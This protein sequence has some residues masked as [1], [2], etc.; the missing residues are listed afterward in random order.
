[1]AKW[2]LTPELLVRSAPCAPPANFAYMF[3][4]PYAAK[5]VWGIFPLLTLLGIVGDA[6]A[7]ELYMYTWQLDKSNPKQPLHPSSSEL[8]LPPDLP[9]RQKLLW[10]Q[11]DGQLLQPDV[12][13]A[14]RFLPV[15]SLARKGS[16]KAPSFHMLVQVV[17]ANE[18]FRELIDTAGTRPNVE[19]LALFRNLGERT[20]QRFKAELDQLELP[21]LSARTVIEAREQVRLLLELHKRSQYL[22]LSA[23]EQ[24]SMLMATCH[25]ANLSARVAF[26]TLHEPDENLPMYN[27]CWVE[28]FVPSEGWIVAAIPRALPGL[29]GR[30]SWISTE[31]SASEAPSKPIELHSITSAVVYG[32]V[33]DG[34]SASSSQAIYLAAL[35]EAWMNSKT[36]VFASNVGEQ[37]FDDVRANYRVNDSLFLAE[38]RALTDVIPTDFSLQLF[39]LT[40][41]SRQGRSEEALPM[42]QYWL[43]QHHRLEPFDRSHL[44]WS[45]A[46]YLAWQGDFDRADY[47]HKQ[48]SKLDGYLPNRAKDADWMRIYQAHPE[49]LGASKDGR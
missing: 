13:G 24:A 21:Q 17:A 22:Q 5:L 7:Q 25:K 31:L 20:A 43:K 18:R 47:Y 9:G 2:A 41:L 4:Y 29:K 28:V 38:S 39:R 6:N 1:M 40:A 32:F 26:G 45:F 27:T 34:A 23:V 30:L 19:D 49:A 46:K 15:D 42:Y 33:G 11:R 36:Q 12:V 48:C 8:L 35:A 14:K 16:R 10:V 3:S 37:M 44:Y